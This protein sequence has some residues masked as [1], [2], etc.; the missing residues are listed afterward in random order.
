MSR[1]LVPWRI[2]C[3]HFQWFSNFIGHSAATEAYR[4]CIVYPW[5]HCNRVVSHIPWRCVWD[6]TITWWRHQMETFSA[7]LALCAGNSPVNGE[8]PGQRPVTW[9]FD[10]SF[11]LRLNKQLSKQSW[12]WWSETPTRSCWRR[13]NELCPSFS[14]LTSFVSFSIMKGMFCLA[15]NSSKLW[16]D[17]PTWKVTTVDFFVAVPA[18]STCVQPAKRYNLWISRRV[19]GVK[20]CTFH[21]LV[22]SVLVQQ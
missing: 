7:S 18:Q 2:M 20:Q 12:G 16:W 13:R 9:S 3:W 6:V 8:F 10:V 21:W 14:L 17:N 11:Y 22:S 15:L 5:L 1:S 4:N 19:T